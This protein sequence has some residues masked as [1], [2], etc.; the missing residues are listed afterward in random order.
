MTEQEFKQSL[1]DKGLAFGWYN[2]KFV[3]AAS[4]DEKE[5]E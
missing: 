2:D 5:A 3:T 1:A 4:I